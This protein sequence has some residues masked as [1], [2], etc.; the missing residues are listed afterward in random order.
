MVKGDLVKNDQFDEIERLSREA[1]KGML[2]FHVAHV[3]INCQSEEEASG[4]ADKFESLFGMK[5]KVGNSSVFAGD[6]IEIAKTNMPGR[7]GHIAVGTSNLER[8][9]YHL[10]K[11][12]IDFDMDTAKYKDGRMISVY[13]REEF[14]G[15]AV[16]LLEK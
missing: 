3:G 9:M 10:G 6:M 4:E 1:V 12:G 13:L 2:N 11:M 16:H 5:K 7:H 15:F 8:A 14:A